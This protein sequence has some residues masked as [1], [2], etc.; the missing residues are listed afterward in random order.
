MG[1][2]GFGRVKGRGLSAENRR[3]QAGCKLNSQLSIDKVDNGTSSLLL[4]DEGSA[5][6]PVRIAF[7]GLGLRCWAFGFGRGDVLLGGFVF[8][9][10]EQF[11]MRNGVALASPQDVSP[12]AKTD[13][14][15]DQKPERHDHEGFT[16]GR[17]LGFEPKMV[18]RDD[19]VG[20]EAHDRTA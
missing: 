6:P 8:E 3:K 16:A 4:S 12:D 10:H 11:P 5:L 20:E 9:F 2:G 17:R 7:P 14:Q 13:E 18:S 19:D 1:K 15:E